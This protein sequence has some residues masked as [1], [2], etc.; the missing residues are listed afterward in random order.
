MFPPELPLDAGVEANHSYII[1]IWPKHEDVGV[2]ETLRDQVETLKDAEGVFWNLRGKFLV[3]VAN[4]VGVSPKE[5]GLQVYAELWKEHLIIDNIILTPARDNFVPTNIKNYT[6][7][8]GKDTLD[9]YTGFP[10]EHGTCGKVTDI[11]LLDQWRL[12]NG[13]FTHN[14]KLFPLK[15]TDNFRGCQIRVASIGIPPYIFLMGNSRL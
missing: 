7:D 8:F 2:I 13:M 10:Y 5:L 1:F 12:R 9:L 11:T 6:D 15:I 3:V 14:S 4:S